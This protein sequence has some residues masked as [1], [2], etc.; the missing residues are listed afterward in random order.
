MSVAGASIP[1]QNNRN[2]SGL[3]K[4]LLQPQQMQHPE[5]CQAWE[6]CGSGLL[7]MGS[8]WVCPDKAL[9]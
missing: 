9:T 6:L 3:P 4:T 7:Q 8:G 2:N 5:V 1:S